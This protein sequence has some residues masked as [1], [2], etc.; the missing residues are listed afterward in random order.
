MT[1]PIA[2]IHNGVW[3]HHVVASAPKYRPFYELVYVHDVTAER[4]A[5]FRAAVIPFQSHQKALAARKHAFYGLLARGG[6][7]FVEG[8]SSPAF[9]DADWA[10]R[11]VNNYWWVNSPDKPPVAHTDHAHPVYQGL[12]PRHAC[13]HTHGV[14]TR[15]PDHAQVIQ[16]NGAGEVITW[17]THA[18]GG[19][20]LATTLDPFVE[21]GVQQIRHLDHYVDNLTLWL[22]GTRPEGI[23]EVDWR[24]GRWQPDMAAFAQTGM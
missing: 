17:Q 20:L 19:T 5:G 2:F 7:L 10:D 23:V 15:V 11:P 22:C 9:L 8:D 16:T 1:K 24:V 4:L 6:K 14:Y 21:H 12:K 18:Y 13:W 3:S